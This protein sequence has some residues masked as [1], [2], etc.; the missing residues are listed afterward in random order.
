MPASALDV[1]AAD[2][3]H[4]AGGDG[5]QVFLN[6]QHGSV[7][8]GLKIQ[9]LHPAFASKNDVWVPLGVVQGPTEP[10]TMESILQ[11][12]LDFFSAHDPG[13]APFK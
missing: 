11:S 5:A 8:W 12:L 2:V 10:S 7:I 9:G 3:A 4:F 6:K 13:V 1:R